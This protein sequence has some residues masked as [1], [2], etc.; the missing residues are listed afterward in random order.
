MCEAGYD[1][2][3]EKE[4][5]VLIPKFMQNQRMSLVALRAALTKR[6]I[7]QLRRLGHRIKG[8]AASYGFFHISALGQ[9]I[10]DSVKTGHLTA[11]AHILDA[12]QD[13]LSKVR[14][15]AA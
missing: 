10:E 15:T 5:W 4:L 3:V 1:V 14:V 9:D 2:V 11:I 7:E 13:Y 12:Y 8:A 6:D